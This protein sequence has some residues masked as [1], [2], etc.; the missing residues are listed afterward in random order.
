[1]LV[2]VRQYFPS[3]RYAVN[4]EPV[5]GLKSLQMR[6]SELKKKS[7]IDPP[8]QAYQTNGSAKCA[9]S[10]AEKK[11]LARMAD[12]TCTIYFHIFQDSKV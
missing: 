11:R 2:V 5:R 12:F 1:M 8:D 7:K 3:V 9:A 4:C 6:M 10:R